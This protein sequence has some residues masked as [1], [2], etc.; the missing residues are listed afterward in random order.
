[1][2]HCVCASDSEGTFYTGASSGQ[3]YIWK[4]NTLEKRIDAHNGGFI[5]SMRCVD[6][7][8]FTGGKDGNVMIWDCPSMAPKKT[9]AFGS[10]IRAIDHCDGQMLVGTRDG[11]I[12]LCSTESEEKKSIMESHNDGEVWGLAS[13]DANCVITSGDDN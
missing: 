9:T 8:L 7:M 12:Q 5:S 10:M 6:Y 4:D 13:M 1:M 11:C 3:I 2:S